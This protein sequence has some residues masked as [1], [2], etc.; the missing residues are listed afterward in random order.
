MAKLVNLQT[1]ARHVSLVQAHSQHMYFLAYWPEHDE[2]QLARWTTPRRL[3]VD[4]HAVQWPATAIL[5]ITAGLKTVPSGSLA[6]I[7]LNSGSSSPFL[8][9]SFVSQT[10]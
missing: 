7:A 3:E 8:R 5:R 4:A 2:F 6:R 1:K 10:A 9:S